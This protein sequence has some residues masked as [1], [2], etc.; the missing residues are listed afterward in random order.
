VTGKLTEVS[1]PDVG[2]AENVEVIE[3][4]VAVG[5]EVA[6]DASLVVLES[7]KA[8][9]EIPAPF[10]GTIVSIAVAQGDTVVE[11][12]LIVEMQA[13]AEAGVKAQGGSAAAA[14]APPNEGQGGVRHETEADPRAVSTV[15]PGVRGPGSSQ[16][17]EEEAETAGGSVTVDVP[18][19][20]V[21]EATDVQV[22]EL[23]VGVGDRV[24]VEGSL[25]VLESDKASMEIPSPVDGVVASVHV[26]LEQV[27][28]TGD[29][30]M[31]IVAKAAAAPQ[32]A[33][34]VEKMVPAE[35]ARPSPALDASRAPGDSEAA[36][37]YA[38]PAVRK[39]AR[40]YGVD[41][42]AVKGTGRKGRVLKE[43]IRAYVK[44]RLAA[45]A[46]STA[47]G[48][49]IPAVPEQDFSRFGEIE[50]IALSRVRRA[51]ARNLHRSW[52]NIPHV[53]QFDDADITDLEQ[54]RRRLN[55]ER[56]VAG[57]KV[58]PLAFLMRAVAATLQA[59]PRFNSSLDAAV[60]NLILKRYCNIG[61]AVDTDDGLVVPVVK[62]VA[63]KGVD[64][65]ARESAELAARARN[66]ELAI[67]DLQGAS[68]TISSLGG[69]GGTAFTP[70]V[71]AP[72]VA[73]L[74]V[75]RTSVKP[76]YVGDVVQPRTILP[77]SLS[78]DHRA[79]DGAEAA[80]FTTYL[81]GVLREPARMLL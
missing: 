21:G 50:V 41:L 78:Y 33:A 27:V 75:S 36:T 3:I 24:E 38:G 53:T 61:I 39:E 46:T 71:N 28:E 40:E 54:F 34:P 63:R 68:F 8:S 65:L 73:I 48:S 45:P 10:A 20:D 64:E 42:T 37:V 25:V 12:D 23:L 15:A 35:I 80:R 26:A 81:A 32:A 76:V 43:D 29:L 49:G 58:T 18:V 5:D 74:G 14:Q 57:L 6:S 16:E 70:I 30:L 52:L 1:V 60:E 4:L 2:E 77:L 51:S 7:D 13:R 22:I 79:L 11:G 66:R 67:D 31:S 59:F 17:A 56:A 69:I 9:M 55:E 19:P 62:D 47:T 72:E 44:A